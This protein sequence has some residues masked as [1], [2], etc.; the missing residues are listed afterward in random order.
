[1]LATN[2]VCHIAPPRPA[3]LPARQ[4]A[5]KTRFDTT[6]KRANG[7]HQQY[8]KCPGLLLAILL[9]QSCVVLFSSKFPC[10]CKIHITSHQST[11]HDP[12]CGWSVVQLLLRGV[13]FWLV[14]FKEII[15]MLHTHACTHTHTHTHTSRLCHKQ[16]QQQQQRRRQH[17]VIH[18]PFILP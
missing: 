12:V 10:Q 11:P 13:K 3:P 6:N 4:L 1:M 5:A 18:D 16:Q 15:N 17:L 7:R 8:Y 2:D 9:D 14:C